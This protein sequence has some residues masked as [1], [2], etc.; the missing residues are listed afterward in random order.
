M[1]MRGESRCAPSTLHDRPEAPALA[2]PLSAPRYALV[3]HR[4]P[5]AVAEALQ[6]LAHG[7]SLRLFTTLRAHGDEICGCH[8]ADLLADLGQDRDL[9]LTRLA[10][11]GLLQMIWCDGNIYYR[12]LRPGDVL[13][14]LAPAYVKPAGMA[15][16]S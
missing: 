6:T 13:A 2:A 9:Y 14:A 12:A 3:S 4:S 5:E 1:S 11:A 7:P 8:I 15:T 10:T 16:S